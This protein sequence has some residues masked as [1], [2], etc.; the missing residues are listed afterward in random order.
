MKKRV[1]THTFLCKKDLKPSTMAFTTGEKKLR[2]ALHCFASNKSTS[3]SVLFRELQGLQGCL[4][5]LLT[6]VSYGNDSRMESNHRIFQK[7]SPSSALSVTKSYSEFSLHFFNTTSSLS[8]LFLYHLR[9]LS[10]MLF[11]LLNKP[12]K[13]ARF[14]HFPSLSSLAMKFGS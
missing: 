8:S 12:N 7:F 5:I 3:R 1:G 13:L 4:S 2:P 10:R 11:I 6:A 9:C 14:N